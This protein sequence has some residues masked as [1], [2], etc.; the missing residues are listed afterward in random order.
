MLS[1]WFNGNTKHL[2]LNH[3]GLIILIS[4]LHL[5][6]LAVKAGKQLGQFQSF[7]ITAVAGRLINSFCSSGPL[8][9]PERVRRLNNEADRI[10]HQ[11]AERAA[12]AAYAGEVTAL[13]TDEKIRRDTVNEV[14]A[15][16]SLLASKGY[17]RVE[18]ITFLERKSNRWSRRGFEEIK[19]KCGA[20]R[21]YSYRSLGL[22]NEEYESWVWL[23]SDGTIYNAQGVPS[24][25]GNP[26]SPAE[27]ATHW[28]LVELGHFRR[29]IENGRLT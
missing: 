10:A 8:S 12:K 25:F 21:I 22:Y 23:L 19:R 18:E 4:G 5:R 15:I 9:I 13:R 3:P 24:R 14:N 27:A 11:N 16:M 20:W 26:Q 2:V 17:P 28:L 1:I 29:S 6:H 7:S